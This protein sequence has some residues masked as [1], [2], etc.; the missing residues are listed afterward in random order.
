[1]QIRHVKRFAHFVQQKFQ[2]FHSF[3]TLHVV[4]EGAYKGCTVSGHIN[5]WNQRHVMRL[6]ESDQFF[7]FFQRVIF[8]GHAGGVRAIIKH[9]ENLAFQSPGLILGQMPVKDV[10]FEFGEYGDFTFEFFQ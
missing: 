4:T 8:A 2:D 5:F 9:R 3:G 6:T 10:D 7:G 1:M